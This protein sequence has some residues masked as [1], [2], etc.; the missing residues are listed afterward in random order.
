AFHR[1][2]K[3]GELR[4]QDHV[5]YSDLDQ[6]DRRF[7]SDRAGKH[8]ERQRRSTLAKPLKRTP[9]VE[10][11]QIKIAKNDVRSRVHENALELATGFD[12]LELTAGPFFAK[13]ALD[14]K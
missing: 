1:G 11:G 4:F 8:E 5:G 6:L 13:R 14:Q 9:R 12:S 7:L 2:R 3:A 10:C